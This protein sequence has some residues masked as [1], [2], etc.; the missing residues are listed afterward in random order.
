MIIIKN[1]VIESC[2]SFISIFYPDIVKKM[3]K[4]V[5]KNK[6]HRFTAIILRK[7][8]KKKCIFKHKSDLV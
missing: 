4:V 5:H 7:I 1:T 2:I 3:T 6:S 8:S